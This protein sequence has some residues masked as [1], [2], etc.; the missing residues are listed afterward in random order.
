MFSLSVSVKVS[1]TD[2]LLFQ[3]PLELQLG[4]ESHPELYHKNMQLYNLSRA[5]ATIL[6]RLL[7]ADRLQFGIEDLLEPSKS[8]SID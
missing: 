7:S 1:T 8:W 3:G 4:G 6:T 5:L 2:V